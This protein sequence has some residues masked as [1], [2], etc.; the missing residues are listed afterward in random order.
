V[1]DW[2]INLGF[3]RWR[4][5]CPRCGGVHVE[6]LNWLAMNPRYTKLF[7]LHVGKLCRDMP[8][9]AVSENERLHH[10]TVKEL[11]KLYMQQQVARAG[12]PAPRAIRINE[13]SIRKGHNYRV[14]VSDLERSRPNWV[15]GEGRMEVDLD[16][17]FAEL[18]PKKSARIEMAVMDMWKPFRNSVTRNTPDA[19]IIFDKFHVI[20]HL[21]DVLDELRLHEYRRLTGTDRSYI[22]GNRYVLLSSRDNLSLEGRHALKKTAR[23]Q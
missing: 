16:R 10:G 11:D 23:R 21:N 4:V 2:R 14:I 8:N 19:R 17:F 20:R 18:G 9:K 22:N 1:D 15:V 6:H 3:E 13:I 7:A 5:N 12:L